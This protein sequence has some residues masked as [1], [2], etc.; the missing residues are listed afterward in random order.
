MEPRSRV[1]RV[2]LVVLDGLRAEAVS[3]LQLPNLNRLASEGAST[4]TAETVSPSVTAAAMTSIFTGVPPSVHG[5]GESG[6][7]VP[8]DLRR[9]RPLPHVLAHAF[10]PKA[11]FT[12]AVLLRPTDIARNA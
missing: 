4:F 3:R 8:G 10:L 6:F 11:T 12:P 1:G 7:G 9:I 5:I 2:V